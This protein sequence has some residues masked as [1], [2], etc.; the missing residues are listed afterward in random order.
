[1]STDSYLGRRQAGSHPPVL[2]SRRLSDRLRRRS[3]A[4]QTALD[5]S[6]MT[7]PNASKI[8]GSSSTTFIPR[9]ATPSEGVPQATSS[10]YASSYSGAICIGLYGLEPRGVLHGATTLR[11][12]VEGLGKRAGAAE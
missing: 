1:M 7:L 2:P 12:L 8:S 4:Q 9:S 10:V 6:P 5:P 3:S 11:G